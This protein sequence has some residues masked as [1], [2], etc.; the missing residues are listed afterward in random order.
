MLYLYAGLIANSL[1]IIES[2]TFIALEITLN[3][4]FALEY[5]AN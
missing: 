2:N 3:I 5:Y 4:I 1:F